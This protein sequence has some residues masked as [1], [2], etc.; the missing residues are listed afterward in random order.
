MSHAFIGAHLRRE[1]IELVGP[2]G[3]HGAHAGI[4]T[5]E[6][7]SDLRHDLYAAKAFDAVTVDLSKPAGDVVSISRSCRPVGQRM[8]ETQE[9]AEDRKLA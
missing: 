8:G 3:I 5:T 9:V 1:F 6:I 7:Y 4:T 2:H